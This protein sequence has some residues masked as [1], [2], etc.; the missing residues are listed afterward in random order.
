MNGV[1]AAQLCAILKPRF[2]VPMHY[3]F[4][5]GPIQDHLALKYTGTP[6]E[7]LRAAAE[8]AP[9]SKARKLSPGEPLVVPAVAHVNA[10]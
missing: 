3:A 7:F 4:F 9:G 6:E 2:A 1:E 8:L 5:G 10:G